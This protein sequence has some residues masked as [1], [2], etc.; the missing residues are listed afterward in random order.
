MSKCMKCQPF[1]FYW[2][3]CY[4]SFRIVFGSGFFTIADLC[5]AARVCN[6]WQHEIIPHGFSTLTHLDCTLCNPMQ[7]DE[8]LAWFQTYLLTSIRINKLRHVRLTGDEPGMLNLF[9][10]GILTYAKLP[11]LRQLQ[12]VPTTNPPIR[13]STNLVLHEIDL[14]CWVLQN[15]EVLYLEIGAYS[16]FQQFKIGTVFTQLKTL[17]IHA[18]AD[19]F[20]HETMLSIQQ[21]DSILWSL[22]YLVELCL[23]L[24]FKIKPFCPNDMGSPKPRCGPVVRHPIV[25]IG[26]YCTGDW[27]LSRCLMTLAPLISYIGR[28]KETKRFCNTLK[29]GHL[30]MK[31]TLCAYH[32][33]C[34]MAITEYSQT[35]VDRA[36]S[37]LLCVPWKEISSPLGDNT[38][39]LP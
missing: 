37:S 3:N 21:F 14:D 18:W 20:P 2:L 6:V 33:S 39:W 36:I 9:C 11:S 27:V 4:E 38:L 23:P 1:S 15:P 22:P 19:I 26:L 12:N 32:N 29:I 28:N 31:Q 16:P 5:R 34:H 25:F 24:A 7:Y 8:F 13:L 17:K 30:K 10:Y 35:N